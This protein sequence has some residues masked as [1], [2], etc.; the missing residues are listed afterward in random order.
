MKITEKVESVYDLGT[1]DINKEN[2][3]AVGP[4]KWKMVEKDIK[5]GR[6]DCRIE[7][8]L[9]YTGSKFLGIF[10]NNILLQTK[11]GGNY[12]NASKRTGDF[13]YDNSKPLKRINLIFPVESEKL[14]KNNN[15]VLIFNDVFKEYSLA[16]IAGFKYTLRAGSLEDYKGNKGD[17]KDIE[18][19]D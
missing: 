18:E 11:D 14:D 7:T 12:I 15:P 3:K 19:M 6:P 17:D 5:K 8:E 2:Y 13:H 10:Y 4:I 1:V 16:T 9:E